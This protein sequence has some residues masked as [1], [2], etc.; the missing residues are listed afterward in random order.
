ML[1]PTALNTAYTQVIPAAQT[2]LTG[3]VYTITVTY[4]LQ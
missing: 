1:T 2:L 3:C 4:T